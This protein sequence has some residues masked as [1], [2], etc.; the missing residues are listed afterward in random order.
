L[1]LKV[2][3]LA[4]QGAVGPHVEK[5]KALGAEPVEVRTPRDL[6]GLAG[7]ILPGGESSTMLHLLRL[8]GLWEPLKAFVAKKPAWG[9]CAGAIL[10]AAKVTGPE[11]ESLGAIRVEVARN[12][13]GRQ[14]ESFIDPL[15]PADDF[16]GGRAFE[17][18]FIRAPR[19]TNVG[20]GVKVLFRH[21]G[22]PVMVEEGNTIAS[23]FHPEL[24]DN[25][26]LHS[27]FLKKLG[28]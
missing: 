9:V 27:Y 16:L 11:Q 23:A 1:S 3:I 6:D 12:A 7:I 28:A 10:L 21:K 19:F 25:T 26:A 4:L 14:L 15:D 18:V 8:N 2:G 22:E 13:Y 5:L 24:T 20:A 17:G